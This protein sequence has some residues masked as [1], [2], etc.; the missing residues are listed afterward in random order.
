MSLEDPSSILDSKKGEWEVVK[1][2]TRYIPPKKA[3]PFQDNNF[4]Y[5]N[6][7]QMPRPTDMSMKNPAVQQQY[8]NFAGLPY[9]NDN[10]KVALP[11]DATPRD[12]K[13]SELAMRLGFRH[14]ST[15]AQNPVS[16]VMTADSNT[17]L[18]PPQQELQLPAAPSFENDFEL[19]KEFDFFDNFADFD[20]QCEQDTAKSV[21]PPTT[22]PSGPISCK[23]E[24]VIVFPV[25]SASIAASKTTCD[26]SCM[27]DLVYSEKHGGFIYM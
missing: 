12:T 3:S 22:V 1:K 25:R 15:D 14:A 23:P 11:V 16:G 24:K 8:N 2:L 5:D 13:P 6:N 19:I 10:S 27:T 26:V 7:G 17:N 20:F 18:P 21:N 4:A 9:E